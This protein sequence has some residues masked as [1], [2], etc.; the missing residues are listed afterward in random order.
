MALAGDN[1]YDIAYNHDLRTVTGAMRGDFLD[2][3]S[4]D[5]IDFSKPWFH[6][7]TDLLTVGGKLFFDSNQFALSGEYMNIVLAIN[8]DF[9]N[10][11][12]IAIPYDKARAGTWYMDDLIAMTSDLAQDINGDGKMTEDDQYG[13]LTSYYPQM[14]IQSNLGGTVVEKNSD[15]MLELNFDEAKLVSI[16]QKTE[17]LYL[18]GVKKLDDNSEGGAGVF[19]KNNSLFIYVEARVLYRT[20]R[21]YDITY[22]ILPF[23]K[24][25]EAQK[26]YASSGFDIYWGVLSSAADHTDM[27]GTIVSAMSCYNYNNIVPLIWELI[28]G[29]KLSDAPDDAEMFEII[30]DVRYVDLSYAFSGISSKLSNLVFLIGK[31]KSDSVMSF[32]ESNREGAELGLETINTTFRDM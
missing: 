25:N 22:G 8:K 15:G 4:I 28:L 2:I 30:R 14:G 31:A 19:V 7:T 26:D 5:T 27:I 12:G 32:I 13:F 24:L 10:N 1:S 29:S 17:E 6:G 3:R 23:P 16:L 18:S 9:A 20:V 21:A 11:H